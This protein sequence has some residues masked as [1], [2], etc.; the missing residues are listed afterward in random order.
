MMVRQMLFGSDA[1]GDGTATAAGVTP[2]CREFSFKKEAEVCGADVSAPLPRVHRPIIPLPL[3]RTPYLE[4]EVLFVSELSLA[5]AVEENELRKLPDVAF[6][7]LDVIELI[8]SS[9][10]LVDSDYV[11][12]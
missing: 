1:I 8:L 7:H 9:Y 5:E 3:R 12:F 11:K 10:T 4:S 2:P 6:L